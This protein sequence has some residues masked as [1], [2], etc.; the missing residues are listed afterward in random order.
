MGRHWDGENVNAN[1]IPRTLDPG[2]A[3]TLRS[4]MPT[5]SPITISRVSREMA[6][7]LVSCALPGDEAYA[8]SVA[9]RDLHSADIW[10]QGKRVA[11]AGCAASGLYLFNLQSEPVA[12]FDS[13]FDFVRFYISRSSLEQLSRDAGAPTTRTLSRPEFGA[14]D[15]VLYNLALSTI[16]ALDHPDEPNQLF[17]DHIALAFHA[18][19]VLSFAGPGRDAIRARSGL[20]PWQARVA[21]EMIAAQLEGNLSIADLASACSLS[22]SHFSRAFVQ[23]L[24]APPHRWLLERR[25][26]RA[27]ELLSSGSLALNDVAKACGFANQSHFSRVFTA[28]T[29]TSPGRW[30]RMYHK[31]EAHKHTDWLE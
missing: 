25:V 12:F 26:D 8:A 29:G 27:R 1:T 17:I 18:H 28:I 13:A 5:R 6:E 7:E 20:A 3:P 11:R 10:L 30:R 14:S 2:A 24:G 22:T 19:L 15:R 16:P 4:S 31:L 9:V 21:T 23:T